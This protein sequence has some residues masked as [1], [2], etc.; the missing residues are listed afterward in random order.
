MCVGE[1]RQLLWISDPQLSKEAMRLLHA[2]PTSPSRDPRAEQSTGVTVAVGAWRCVSDPGSQRRRLE[3]LEFVRLNDPRGC[4]TLLNNASGFNVEIMFA[5][6][7]HGRPFAKEGRVA[8]RLKTGCFVR[9]PPSSRIPHCASV[10]DFTP[11]LSLLPKLQ[12]A[13]PHNARRR[14]RTPG[15]LRGPLKGQL[16]TEAERGERDTDI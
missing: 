10:S 14:S 2:P 5:V 15:C 13:L 4:C 3:V 1:L 6:F 9:P 16:A 11:L 12:E 7:Y 8:L